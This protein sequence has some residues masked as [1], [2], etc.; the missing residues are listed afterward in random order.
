MLKGMIEPEPGGA[1]KCNDSHDRRWTEH[2]RGL[3]CRQERGS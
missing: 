2:K 1:G 3:L